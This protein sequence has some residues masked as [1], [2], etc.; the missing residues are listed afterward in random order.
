[1]QYLTKAESATL[2]KRINMRPVS[3]GFR[4][5]EELEFLDDPL[6]LWLLPLLLLWYSHR[7]VLMRVANARCGTAVRPTE[8]N[9]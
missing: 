5:Q 4:V 1:L 2:G 6:R 9:R 8:H 3:T 7:R